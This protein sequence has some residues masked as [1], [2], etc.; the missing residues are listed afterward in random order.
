MERQHV[1]PETAMSLHR[2]TAIARSVFCPAPRN[3]L[4]ARF[5]VIDVDSSISGVVVGT[6][7]N[8]GAIGP[9]QS[10][11]VVFFTPFILVVLAQPSIYIDIIGLIISIVVNPIGSIL[12]GHSIAIVFDE[13]HRI[14]Y[15]SLVIFWRYVA[16]RFY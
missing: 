2:P 15:S 14:F 11:L 3:R 10:P 6:A 7:I 12:V 13:L 9:I 4:W 8:I 1:L 16:L 5:F